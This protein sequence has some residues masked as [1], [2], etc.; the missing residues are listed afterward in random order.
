M[1]SVGSTNDVIAGLAD[2]GAPHGTV[3]VAHT[4]TAGR[5][6]HG[7]QWFSPPGSGLYLSCLLRMHSPPPPVLTLGTGV[8]VAEALATAA[9]VPAFLDWPNDVMTQVEGAP[10]KVAGIL[11]EAA[12]EG[13]R[14]RVV[15][16]IGI[17]LRDSAWPPE[18]VGVAASVEGVTAQP[19][20][21]AALLV[22]VLAGLARRYGEVESGATA[23]LLAR[24]ESLAPSSRG[25]TVEW[26]SGQ[27]RRRGV[28]AGID[29]QGALRVRVGSRMER[30]TGGAVR[31]VR[32][33]AS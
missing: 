7:H 16:G 28:S 4:Q 8:A 25:A 31:Q 10:R 1:G 27:T 13:P 26:L 18:L 23:D 24:W 30:L 19:V 20:D 5:G 2:D 9:G 22:E 12:T 17:N 29:A 15:V 21:A 32:S 11:T 3:V 33:A 6:R 14:A